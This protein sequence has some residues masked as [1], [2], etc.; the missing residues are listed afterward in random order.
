VFCREDVVIPDSVKAMA[1]MAVDCLG[2]EF[3]AVDMIQKKDTDS[4]YVLEV[5]TRP[6][7]EGQTTENY[8][9]AFAEYLCA[10]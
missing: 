4:F 3:G 6:G 1:A 9:K 5:N 2:L 10:V 8:A 7:L